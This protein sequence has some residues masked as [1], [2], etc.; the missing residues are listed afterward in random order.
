MLWLRGRRGKSASRKSTARSLPEFQ[1]VQKYL[2]PAGSY[3]PYRERTAGSS[4]GA[5]L[6]KTAK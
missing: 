3:V 5:L 1:H 4:W 2:G 6:K